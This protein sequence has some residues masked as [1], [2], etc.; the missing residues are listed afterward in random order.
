MSPDRLGYGK[1]FV[2]I[3]VATSRSEEMGGGDLSRRMIDDS[4]GDISLMRLC[5]AN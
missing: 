1:R 3:N 4:A 2:F 5:N